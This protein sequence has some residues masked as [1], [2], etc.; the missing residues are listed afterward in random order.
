MGHHHHHHHH[1]TGNIKVAFF[2]NLSFTIIEII[3]GLMTNS[4]AI[5]ADAL[6]DLGDSLSLGISWFLEKVSEKKPD[7][8]FT[9][10]YARFSLLAAF[11]NSIVLIVGSMIIL[12]HVIPRLLNP[13][14]VEASGMLLLS[15]LG[16]VMNGLAVL[17]LK[18]GSSMNEKVVTWHLMEDILGWVVVLVA[19][20][21]LM[22]VDWPIIDP[23]LSLGLT[24]YILYNVVGNL[25]EIVGIFL[26][27]TPSGVSKSELKQSLEEELNI[28]THHLH[29]WSL[30]GERTMLSL[31]L[32]VKDDLTTNELIEEKSRVR[33]WLNDHEIDHVTLELEF[34][35]EFCEAS[36]CE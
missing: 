35:K 32:E 24:L 28:H 2:L 7:E 12:Y 29:L 6:H 10:G 17:R 18:K 33:Q 3:G 27:K 15:I 21:I 22:F 19:S 1:E 14:P 34:E 26:Q 13:E 25:K 20:V 30:D 36:D 31:H 16:I 23:L 5:L 11:I 9:F 4:M 8:T